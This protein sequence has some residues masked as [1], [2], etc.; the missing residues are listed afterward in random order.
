MTK[1]YGM[2]TSS[3]AS[4]PTISD[5]VDGPDGR[6][7]SVHFLPGQRLPD[8]RNASRIRILAASGEGMITID[9]LGTRALRNGEAVQVEANVVHSLVAGA[10]EWQVEVVLLPA[11]CSG[12]A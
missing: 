1:P 6:S 4:R 12:C 9:G 3:P 8:H 10:E 11:C 7:F 2:H 5:L